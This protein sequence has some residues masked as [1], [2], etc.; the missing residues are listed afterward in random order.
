[1]SLSSTLGLGLLL[2]LVSPAAPALAQTCT[3]TIPAAD[4]VTPGKV[5]LSINPTLPPLQSVNAQGQLQGYNVDL[6]NEIS[7]RICMPV[8]LL[9][10]DFPAMIPGL[11]AGRFDGINTGMFWTEE[12]SKIMFTVPY[13]QAAI[14]VIVNTD[15][16]YKPTKPE[17]LQGY[18][19]AVDADSYQ[20]RWLRNFDKESVAKGMKPMN[21]R[22]FITPTEVMAALRAGQADAAALPT[23]TT[24]ELVRRG[25]AAS[26]IP[27]IGATMTTMA[28]RKKSVA[29]AVAKALNEMAAD[30]TYDR[31][32]GQIGMGLPEKTFGIRGPGPSS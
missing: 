29:Q 11:G 19:I 22:A 4:L 27:A 18:T 13:A 9:R 25:Q 5:Q 14:G 17:E 2:A 26:A 10:M 32:F 16:K 8:E 1:M 23:Y 21:I 7:K 3:S 31:L 28:F 24:T 12:R 30:G 15:S 6:A 20:E